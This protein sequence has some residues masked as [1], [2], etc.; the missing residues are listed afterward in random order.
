MGFRKRVIRRGSSGPWLF[1]T[2]LFVSVPFSA[3]A[4]RTTPA[5]STAGLTLPS[6]SH[7]QMAVLASY[8]V[9][10]MDL[11]AAQY[12]ADEKMQQIQTFIAL[13]HFACAWGWM[14]H[15]VSDENSPFNECSHAYLAGVRL[16]LLHLETM[17]GDRSAVRALRANVDRAMLKT[18]ASLV[19][20]NFSNE[21][22][23]TADV[24]V[25]HP[26]DVLTDSASLAALAI[27]AL[28]A[29]MAGWAAAWLT[30]VLK[31]EP[32][33]AEKPQAR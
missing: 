1:A 7:G 12:P 16:L 8:R 14:P 9:A 27:L 31:D 13:Q 23:N 32:C 5:S 19:L 25:P 20:C 33:V 18:H 22:F 4:H 15:S 6:V 21:A 3:M 26:S 17:Q 24:V 2:V 28:L 10:V 30:Q 29:A 11:A